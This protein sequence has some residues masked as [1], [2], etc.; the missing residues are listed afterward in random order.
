M[1]VTAK[2][3]FTPAEASGIV[4]V[5]FSLDA[6][7]LES[8]KLVALETLKRDKHTVATHRDT[9]DAEQTITVTNGADGQGTSAESMGQT[10][11]GGGLVLSI[12]AGITL[13]V[14]GFELL[15]RHGSPCE[16]ADGSSEHTDDGATDGHR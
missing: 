10:G 6:T 16:S 12:V 1:P 7:G 3:T 11:V 5:E 4:E 14:I 13:A 9:G 8:K 15:V 2:A